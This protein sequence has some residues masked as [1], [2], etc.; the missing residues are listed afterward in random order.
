MKCQ[1]NGK[2]H[3]K[4]HRISNSHVKTKHKLKSNIKKKRIFNI[5]KNIWIKLK[6]STK[7]LK[8]FSKNLF[9]NI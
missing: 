9:T 5:K 1:I 7:A 2:S 4:S 8:T 3:I 6:I